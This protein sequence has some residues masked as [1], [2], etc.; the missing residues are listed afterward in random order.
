VLIVGSILAEE[1][2][3]AIETAY[4]IRPGL[5]PLEEIRKFEELQEA[6]DADSPHY[7]VVFVDRFNQPLQSYPFN[8]SER[9][10][11][12]VEDEEEDLSFFL[13]LPWPAGTAWIQVVHHQTVLHTLSVSSNP[14]TVRVLEPN[15]GEIYDDQLVVRWE[16]SDEDI[17]VNPFRYLRHT[18][19]YSVDGGATWQALVTNPSGTEFV[20]DDAFDLAGSET[21]LIRVI[22]SDGVNTSS[23]TSDGVF[24]VTNR[25]PVAHISRPRDG[26]RFDPGEQIVLIGN[27]WDPEDGTLTGNSALWN[28]RGS[29]VTRAGKDALLPGLAPG[30]YRIQLE[31][32]DSDGNRGSD[33]VVIVVDARGPMQMPGDVNQD[34]SLDLS[35]SIALLDNLF[36]GSERFEFLPC[37][38]GSTGHRANIALLD[39][40]GDS[41]IDLSDSVFILQFLFQ[42]GPPPLMGGECVEISGCPSAAACN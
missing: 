6:R 8:V 41:S 14:P 33:E 26:D 17:G 38:D 37:G 30:T 23:D 5:V 24:R 15:G 10:H 9:S 36:I 39:L 2:E 42:G 4:R 34:G 31:G 25:Q 22:V 7:D 32:V 21:A 20:I 27:A 29:D 40:N 13:L 18:V 28:L 12:E 11:H 19:Q 3:G 35:D 16:S 1:T